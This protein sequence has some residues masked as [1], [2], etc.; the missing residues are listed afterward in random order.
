ME[1]CLILILLYVIINYSLFH[2]GE[3][4]TCIYLCIFCMQFWVILFVWLNVIP[5]GVNHTSGWTETGEESE[6]NPIHPSNSCSSN[7][8]W[9]IWE[10]LNTAATET[11]KVTYEPFIS[12]HEIQTGCV[13]QQH[14]TEWM[15]PLDTWYIWDLQQ[16]RRGEKIT[17]S[18]LCFYCYYYYYYTSLCTTS[19][20]AANNLSTA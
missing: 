5:S 15:T 20:T 3:T 2:Q 8:H 1:I 9:S 18:V 17:S 4:N 10:L 6:S 12:E 13:H 7:S 19:N 16:Y 11:G 14:L